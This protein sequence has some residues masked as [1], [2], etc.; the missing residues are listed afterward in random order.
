MRMKVDEITGVFSPEECQKII[1]YGDQFPLE[2]NRISSEDDPYFRDCR[3]TWLGVCPD[4]EWMFN[5]FPP[6]FK[7]YPVSRL[8]V[9]QFTVYK[10]GHYCEWHVDN[11]GKSD[12]GGD[13]IVTAIVQLTDPAEYEGGV[14]QILTKDSEKP[15]DKDDVEYISIPPKLGAVIFFAG[16]VCHR[17]TPVTRG[18]RKVLVCWGLK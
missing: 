12:H 15:G 5:K 9:L 13:R 10:E 1:E 6:I 11:T 14:L 17:V 3:L 4:T 2:K 16:G 18:E 8:E 7:D